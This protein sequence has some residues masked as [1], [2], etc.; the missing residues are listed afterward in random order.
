MEQDTN[1]NPPDNSGNQDDALGNI[2]NVDVRQV[3]RHE[4]HNFTPWLARKTWAGWAKPCIL[5]LEP[6]EDTEVPGWPLLLGH[7]GPRSC[8]LM[9]GKSP[10]RTN[11]SVDGPYPLGAAADLRRRTRSPRLRSG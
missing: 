2:E 7:S 3:W 11:S 10:L 4:A 1:T 8:I 6:A 5:D 9:A